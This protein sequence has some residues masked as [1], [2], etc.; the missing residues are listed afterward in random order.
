MRKML[1]LLIMA[2]LSMITIAQTRRSS[3][4]SVSSAA[5]STLSG[6]AVTIPVI[7]IE[8]TKVLRAVDPKSYGVDCPSCFDP[9]WSHNAGFLRAL[10]TVTDGGKP[11][12]RLHGW[13]MVSQGS[14]QCWLNKDGTWNAAK[15]KAA[16][17]PLVQAGYKLMID[18]PSG[19]GGDKNV[20]DLRNPTR[21]ASFAAA[22]VKIV[23]VDNH[24]RVKYWEIPNEQ[25][26]ILTPIQM[27][28]LLTDASIA[29]KSVDP[30][31]LV[32]GPAA[33]HIDVDYIAEVVKQTWPHLDFISAHTYGGDGKQTDAASYASAKKVIAEVRAL[34]TR[35]RSTARGKYLPIFIDEYNIGWDHTPRIYNNEGAV[36]FSLIQAGV[37]D[38]GGDVSAIW[39]CS[40]PHNM[41]IVDPDGNLHVSANLFSLMNKYFYGKEVLANSSDNT[42]LFVYAVEN[43][44]THSV[45][46]SNL[47]NSRQVVALRFQG[48]N[49]EEISEYQISSTGYTGPKKMDW[50]GSHGSEIT[51]PARSVTVLVSQ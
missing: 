39:D 30:T 44:S 49:P 1:C 47:S 5:P 41:S 45:V 12:I 48:W 43:T 23:N 21:M 13:G 15:I 51:V 7:N 50:P 35:L 42:R 2:L 36:Y 14:N 28:S 29:M 10:A 3:S 6:A 32:G 24:F 33:D 19:P 27:A 8:W 20:R 17:T 18:I 34:R 40:P 37:V 38:A 11:L 31:I 4:G 25:E 46:L 9:A 26:T 22:L 16:L